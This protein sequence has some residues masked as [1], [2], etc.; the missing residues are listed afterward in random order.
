MTAVL[1]YNGGP[2]VELFEVVGDGLLDVDICLREY[3]ARGFP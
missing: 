3:V 1:T 2:G